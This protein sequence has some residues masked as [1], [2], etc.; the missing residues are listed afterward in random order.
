MFRLRRNRY[1]DGNE[2]A[3]AR[4]RKYRL[5]LA[6][7]ADIQS[8]GELPAVFG[9][10]RDQGFAPAR[11]HDALEHV[12]LG[13]G[14]GFVS[15]IETGVETDIDAARD[16]PERDVRCLPA[17]VGRLHAPGFHRIEAKGPRCVCRDSSPGIVMVPC[18]VRLPQFDDGIADRR[19]RTIEDPSGKGD[20]RTAA[21]RHRTR[22]EILDVG[23]A[24][25][26]KTRGH[27]DVHIRARGLR[28][29][30]LKRRQLVEHQLPSIL[31]SKMVERDPRSTISKR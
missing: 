3:N 10:G 31:F 14:L 28:G 13:V 22:A 12:V 1:P 7:E 17:A 15:V 21:R 23:A 20:A 5:G 2:K 18:A 16:D 24:D 27:A 29:R 6:L 26:L 19:A 25:A 30:L 11:I 9:A 8:V 4:C